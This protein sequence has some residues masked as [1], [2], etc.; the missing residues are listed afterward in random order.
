[1]TTFAP[2]LQLNNGVEMPAFGLGVYQSPP[3]QTVPAVE[4][5]LRDG[6]RLIDTAAAYGNEAQVGEGLRRS[7]VVR[8]EVFVTTKL[9]LTDYGY[10]EA[11]RAF[12]HSLGELGLDYLDL[13]LLHW[14]V[15]SAFD[16]TVASYEAAQKLLADGRVR[17][18]GV[19][20]HA[21]EDL[22][23]LMERTEIVPAVNQVELHPLFIQRELRDFDRRNGIITQSW[24]PIGGVNRYGSNAA[25]QSTDPLRAPAVTDIAEKYGKTPAQVVLRWHLEHS[26]CAIP[27]SVKE[28][29]IK[30]NFDVFDF[31][32]TDDEVAAIDALDGG[33]RGGAD[34]A[35]VR[36]DSFS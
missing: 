7:D 29:R 5:A 33:R 15:P 35:S 22:T 13:Y 16:A 21:P 20:N 24:S 25:D 34:P 18:I 14:P 3:E 19:C 30:E 9:W 1:M 10:D 36:L 31:S 4:A 26:L 12:D 6:Y 8:E 17:A 11:L 28:H 27:K 23:R 32:L 2:V